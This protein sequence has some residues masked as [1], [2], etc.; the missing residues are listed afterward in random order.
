L[1]NQL[2]KQLAH[3]AKAGCR[4]MIYVC[5]L[6]QEMAD[7]VLTAAKRDAK[8]TLETIA[9][10]GGLGNLLPLLNGVLKQLEISPASTL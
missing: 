7:Q 3:Y 2:K 5:N 8:V 6:S 9:I 10:G 1:A 4:Q